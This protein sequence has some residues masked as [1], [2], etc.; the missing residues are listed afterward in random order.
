M[1][2]QYTWSHRKMDHRILQTAFTLTELLV[3]IAI[4]GILTALLLPVLSKAKNRS[5][6]LTDVNNIKQQLIALHLYA[7]DNGDTLPWPNWFEGD[8]STNGVPRSGW[9]YTLDISATGP[10]RFNLKTGLFWNTLRDPRL[11]MCPIDLTNTPLFAQ[12]D[13]QISSYVLNGAV[14]GYD[15]MSYPCVRLS[16]IAPEAVAF[17]ETDEQVPHYFNDGSSYPSEGVSA[18]HI[19]GAMTGTFDGSASFM[20]YDIWYDQADSTNKNQLWC[21]PGSPNG[22]YIE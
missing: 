6:M 18:R 14:S 20:K 13:Q 7:S 8:V 21:Y 17:W 15:L 10:A 2:I 1:Q 12:R 3:V 11:Y 4:I 16:N 9:L 5:T 19:Q 22:R